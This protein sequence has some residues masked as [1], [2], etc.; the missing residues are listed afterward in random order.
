MEVIGRQAASQPICN[1]KLWK[2]MGILRILQMHECHMCL[3]LASSASC[4]ADH[5]WGTT[6][7]GRQ[8]AQ[9]GP[10]IVED[11]GN[12]QNSPNAQASYV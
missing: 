1:L 6:K 8:A 2:K 3:D 9:L 12:L 5:G 4:A 10:E 11:D 7:Q